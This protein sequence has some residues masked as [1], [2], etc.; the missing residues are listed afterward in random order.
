MHAIQ[1]SPL[2]HHKD[3]APSPPALCFN[4]LQVLDLSPNP[5]SKI[6]TRGTCTSPQTDLKHDPRAQSIARSSPLPSQRPSRNNSKDS[7]VPTREI[8]ISAPLSAISGTILKQ[9]YDQRRSSCMHCRRFGCYF[10]PIMEGRVLILWSRFKRCFETISRAAERAW[11]WG[12]FRCATCCH[13]L[14]MIR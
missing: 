1:S 13:D 14:Q 3:P 11:G 12:R 4:L 8:N 2:G 9:D 6:T 7:R 5:A 10:C